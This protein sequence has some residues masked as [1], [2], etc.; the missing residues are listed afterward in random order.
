MNG[1]YGRV[2]NP[3]ARSGGASPAREGAALLQGI[4]VCGLCGRR[5]TVRY[6]TRS[7]RSFPDYRCQREAHRRV[8]PRYANAIPGARIDQAIGGLLLATITPVALGSHPRRPGMNCGHKLDRPTNS[9][10]R[11]WSGP[12]TKLI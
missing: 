6:R 12:A 5:M 11:R 9:G 1:A 8:C 4:V 2:P 7:G 10:T 3:T